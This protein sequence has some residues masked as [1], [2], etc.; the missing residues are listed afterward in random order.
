MANRVHLQEEI[1]FFTRLPVTARAAAGAGGG[2]GGGGD[3]TVAYRP[4]G[5]PRGLST[6]QMTDRLD[7]EIL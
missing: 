2:G 5:S 4:S 7:G 6:A 3:G 1:G